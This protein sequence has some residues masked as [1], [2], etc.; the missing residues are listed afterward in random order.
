MTKILNHRRLKLRFYYFYDEVFSIYL[1]NVVSSTF[2]KF[3]RLG[4]FTQELVDIVLNFNR[5]NTV[6]SKF[7][8]EKFGRI[9]RCVQSFMPR[10]VSLLSL[11]SFT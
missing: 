4:C 7:G 10:S 1:S 5:L 8:F 11:E 3:C 9:K 6:S 2:L